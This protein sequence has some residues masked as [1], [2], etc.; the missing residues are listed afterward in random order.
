MSETESTSSPEITPEIAEI[1]KDYSSNQTTVS[2]ISAAGTVA[3]VGAV[4]YGGVVACSA[5]I[6]AGTAFLA[7]LGAAMAGGYLGTLAG[8]ALMDT[9]FSGHDVAKASNI[10]A[11]KGHKIV[12]NNAFLG[13]LGALAAGIIGAVAIGAL[14]FFTGGIGLGA[15]AFIGFGSGLIGGASTAIGNRWASETG[16]IKDGSPNVFFEDK[17]VA[18]VTDIVDCEDHPGEPKP[19]IAQGST[20]V[21]INNLALARKGDKITCSAVIQEGCQTIFAD[22]TSGDY[23]PIDADM[24]VME[25]LIVSGGEVISTFFG[26][27]ILNKLFKG[28]Q[29]LG[30][31]VDTG[32]GEYTESRTD[33]NYPHALPLILHRTYSGRHPIGGLLGS[34]WRCNWS[35]YLEFDNDGQTVTY[36]DTEGLCPAYYTSQEPFNGRNLLVP[37]YRLLGN[38]NRAMIFDE[39]TQQCYVFTPVSQG[40]K[41]LRL[42]AI[43]DRNRNEIR[44][45]Y[46]GVGHLT[47][48]EHS[49]GLCLRVMCGPEGQIYRVCDGADG[50]ELVRYDYI[51]HDDE[52]WLRDAQT[53]FNGTLHY[54]YTEQGWLN[55]WRDN[56]PTHFHLRYDDEGRVVATGTEE[57]LYND[58][59][60]YFPAERRTEYTDA[61]GAVTTL[62]FDETWLLIKQ[63]DPQ[64]RVTEWERNEYDQPVCIRQ[65]GG[66]A[67]QIKR[68]QAGRILSETDA[69][70]RKREWQWNEFGQM[71]AYRDHR[72]TAAYRY[73]NE[74]NLIAREVNGRTWQYR[75][76][77]DGQVKAVTYPDGSREQWS[78]NAQGSL[79][80]HTDAE[81]RTTHYTEDR[82]LRLTGM[83]DA[84]GRSTQWQYR[85]G[86]DN[87]H[88]KVSTVIRPDGGAETFRYDGEGKIAVHTGAMGQTT[89]FR[90]GAFDLLREV[91]DAGGQRIVCDYDG[92]ARLTQLTRSGNQRWRLYYDA[93]GQLAGEDDWSG[94][95]TVYHRDEQGR[96]AE[97]IR[98]DGSVWRY[99]RDEYGRVTAISGEHQQLR[100]GYDNHDR[101]VSAEV[102]ECSDASAQDYTLTSRITLEWDERHRLVA[103]QQD[104]QRTEYRYDEA[105]RLTGTKT[106]DGETQREYD[107]SGVLTAY[108]SNGHRMDFGHTW[109][110]QEKQR[111]YRPEDEET[112][113]AQTPLNHAVYMQEQ[114]YDACGRT[115][116]QRQGAERLAGSHESVAS[117]RPL[118]EHRYAWDKSGRL[119]GHEVWSK[120][121]TEQETRYSYDNRDQITNVLRL[122]ADGA[123]QEERYRYTVNEQL[124]ESRINGILSQHGYH[125]ECVTQAGNSR[126]EYDACGR[127]IKRTE[128]KRGFRPQEWRYRWDDFDR[129]REVRTP[130]GEVWQYRYDAFGRRTAKRSVMRAAWRKSHHTVSEVRYQWQGMALSASE[131]RYADGSPALREQWHY[132]GGFELLAK[133]ARAANDDTSYFYPVLCGPDGAPEEM[134][135]ANGRKVWTRQRS[136]WGLAAANDSP[137]NDHESCDAGFMGQWRD[138]E[139]GLWYNLHRYYDAGTGQYLSPDP[140]KLGGGLN[141]QSYVSNPIIWVDPLGLVK[142]C[143]TETFV[144]FMSEEEA[145]RV[146]DANGLVPSVNRAT[147]ELNR[148]P[149]WISLQGSERPGTSK[150]N[151]HKVTFT[152]K[153]GTVAKLEQRKVNFD[154]IDGEGVA[155]GKVI[156]KDNEPGSFGVGRDILDVFNENIIGKIKIE[157]VK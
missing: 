66:R 130:D 106:A 112:W 28:L 29:C 46:N 118:G 109:S 154:D 100:Y 124:A 63:R 52:W 125:N 35:Q 16:V 26:G 122:N 24:S 129:L 44:F 115:A 152:V 121:G 42:S 33:F 34:R 31:P 18:R 56:G 74:G 68:D 141:T 38:R 61:T 113:L 32:T 13:A 144:R 22:D 54:T 40:D 95:R 91:E 6:V 142:K 134:Y 114:G 55:S 3:S 127:V 108:R 4:I 99:A 131:K 132:R 101:M 11:C 133:E 64:G 92:A 41:H 48:V 2:L 72:T 27:K 65:P 155:P 156:V 67:T 71:A 58:T 94:R 143:P 47:N 59:F 145:A 120:A 93:A 37:Q 126:Y 45:L 82:W 157:K 98:P 147:G 39:H 19:R 62:W 9:V 80:A 90:H 30:D 75:H 17:P 84:E 111:R 102:Y 69:D 104:G 60:R 73:N 21:F 15:L 150:L 149:R 12:H 50:S 87:P 123:A 105:G 53:R 88:E 5:G 135:S 138:E 51:H 7:P 36:I 110:G 148:K 116:W 96:L 14:I 117:W 97:K 81:G 146:R 49:S 78:Y 43:K 57:G 86:E 85:P 70:G 136:L 119:T 137:Y 8:N 103:E 107:A 77:E 25:Q 153:E 79:T 128:Q 20:T 10:P 89:R 83:T 151:T 76:T 140:L 139:S 23:L 1:S